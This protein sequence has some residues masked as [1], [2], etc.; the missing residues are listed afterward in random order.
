[1]RSI[2]I[3]FVLCFLLPLLS[4]AHRMTKWQS[5]NLKTISKIYSLTVY[6]NNV[7]LFGKN[8]TNS[9]LAGL[10]ND[11]ATGRIDPVGTFIDFQDSIEYFFGLAPNAHASPTNSVFTGAEVV[12]YQSACPEVASS[13]AYLT[14]G[15]YN[16]GQPDDGIFIGTLKQVRE[17]FSGMHPR[18]RI[19][20]SECGRVCQR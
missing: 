14:A 2:K 11:K 5:R 8:G 1:M 20:P 7:G 4:K 9:I 17:P 15:T 12:E 3:N 10:F 13:T 16:P 19:P 6:P 18:R